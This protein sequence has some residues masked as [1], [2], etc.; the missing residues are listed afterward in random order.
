MRDDDR[1][2]RV[3][4][5]PVAPRPADVFGIQSGHVG[6]HRPSHSLGVGFLPADVCQHRAFG[7]SGNEM[8]VDRLGLPEP[9]ESADGLINLLKAVV[10]PDETSIGAV[11]PVHSKPADRRFSNQ[12]PNAAVAKLDQLALFL[13]LAIRSLDIDRAGDGF[14]HG[15]RFGVQVAPPHKRAVGRRQFHRLLYPQLNGV[16]PRSDALRHAAR[17]QRE[18]QTGFHARLVFNADDVFVLVQWRKVVAAILVSEVGWPLEHDRPGTHPPPEWPFRMALQSPLRRV[19]AVVNKERGQHVGVG[20]DVEKLGVIAQLH[21]VVRARR[22]R[23]G[24]AERNVLARL[25]KHGPRLAVI[26]FEDAAFIQHHGDEPRQIEL[27]QLLVIGHVDAVPDI[28]ARAALARLDAELCRLADELSRHLVHGVRP[29]Q[30]HQRLAKSG[31]RKDGGAS[32]AQRPTHDIALKREQD[33]R[34]VGDIRQ[35]RVGLLNGLGAQKVSINHAISALV[36]TPASVRFSGR[37]NCTAGS[38]DTFTFLKAFGPRSGHG[39]TFSGFG[40][41][42]GNGSLLF[43]VTLRARALM[44]L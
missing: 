23:R 24:K 44:L 31:A 28:L 9:P 29:R 26:G 38:A 27:G 4:V 18:Q 25:N 14:R 34:K 30:F 32:T 2:G 39:S 21:K 1:H 6:N 35:S 15:F 19:P 22:G 7:F 40:S 10:E 20:H 43:A 3:I 5:G 42:S 17:L 37:D 12:H 41:N 16:F 13:S 36:P 11:L 8:D 33:A